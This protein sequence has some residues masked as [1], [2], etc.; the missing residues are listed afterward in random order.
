[1]KIGPYDLRRLTRS[2]LPRDTVALAR[3]L[4]GKVVVRDLAEAGMLAGRII[5]T[6]AYIQ[7]DAACHA[8]NGM[9]PRNR[10][11]FLR[12]GHAYVYLAYGTAWMLNVSSEAEGVGSGVLIRA[13]E[14]MLGTE[15]MAR[16]R[17]TEKSRDLLRGPGRIAQALLIDRRLDGLDLTRDPRL[18]L[19]VEAKMDST[20]PAK[21]GVST[22][23]GLTKD[24][25]RP[26]RFFL[27]G[28]RYVSGPAA[29]N[30]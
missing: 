7:G 14:P 10:S 30:R 15:T 23:I 21:I 27:K 6:E 18:W 24:A 11:L 8:F 22:R 9:T 16:H 17:G 3:F 12:H 2:Q 29:L 25:Q 26:L 28:S 19:G 1:M 20:S 5:E 13:L 4:I